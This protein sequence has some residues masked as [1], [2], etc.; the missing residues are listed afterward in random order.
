MYDGVVPLL[1]AFGR[2][3]RPKWTSV[4]IH[5]PFGEML[6]RGR[7]QVHMKIQEKILKAYIYVYSHLY[8]H[9]Y[10]DFTYENF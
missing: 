7:G 3:S 9:L 5:Q 8:S 4:C 1:Q 6:V 10:E 2:P